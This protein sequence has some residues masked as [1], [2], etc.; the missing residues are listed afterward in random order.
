MQMSRLKQAWRI[1]ICPGMLLQ[2]YGA[3]LVLFFVALKPM[4]ESDQG[5]VYFLEHMLTFATGGG[6]LAACYV[7]MNR[8]ERVK[9][10]KVRRRTRGFCVFFGAV[11]ALYGLLMVCDLV[12]EIQ[13]AGQS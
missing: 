5:A 8:Y 9:Q 3:V 6:L 4:I 12:K 13:R 2:I 11:Y 7:I 10:V 1:W